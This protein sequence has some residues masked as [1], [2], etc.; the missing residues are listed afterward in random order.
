MTNGRNWL[1]I[2]SIAAAVVFLVVG[3]ILVIYGTSGNVAVL[4]TLIVTTIPAL[5][6]AAYSERT[7]RDLDTLKSGNISEPARTALDEYHKELHGRDN[8]NVTETED[9]NDGRSAL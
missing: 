8:I 7:S 1:P 9:R 2:A 6:A 4:L 3:T 5:I